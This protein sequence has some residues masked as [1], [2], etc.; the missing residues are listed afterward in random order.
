MDNVVSF[1]HF[2]CLSALLSHFNF[3][4]TP[5]DSVKKKAKWVSKPKSMEAIEKANGEIN[6]ALLY[7][8]RKIEM[9]PMQVRKNFIYSVQPVSNL[10]LQTKG[11]CTEIRAL[12]H[13]N[14][15]NRLQRR[16]RYV[17]HV[18]QR[19]FFDDPSDTKKLSY[20]RLVSYLETI[21][22][23]LSQAL[24]EAEHASTSAQAVDQS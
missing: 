16:D 10:L 3:L 12:L 2:E 6:Q 17:E 5:G 1:P 7:L 13:E 18:F 21:N 23:L 4:I 20:A 14:D 15:S 22:Q 24:L 19:I 9:L 11:Y 8:I